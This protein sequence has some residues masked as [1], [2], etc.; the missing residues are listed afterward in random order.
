M[1]RVN[2]LFILAALSLSLYLVLRLAPGT[3]P[4]E[5]SLP[6]AGPEMPAA[7]AS[8][9]AVN[10]P[11]TMLWS[12]PGQLRDYDELILREKN[13]PAAWAGGMDPAMR[14]WLV[15]KADT[16]ALFGEAVHILERR[17]DWLRVA[18]V[19]QKT[20]LNEWGYPGW[21]PAGHIAGSEVYLQEL[22]SLP[23]VVVAKKTALLYS[24]PGLTEVQ[25]EVSYQT[26]LPLLEEAKDYV[27]VRLPEGGTGF[28]PRQDVKKEEDLAFSRSA[29]VEEAR[30]FLGVPYLWAGT[31]SY[32]FDCSGFT[33]RLYQSQGLEIPRD[34]DE[35]AR[36]GMGVARADIQPGDLLFY[37]AKGGQGQIHHVGLYAGGGLMIHAPNSHSAVRLDA[38]DSG[39]YGEEYW[40]ARRYA[41]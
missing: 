37:A 17:G 4:P 30:Q 25:V 22:G 16:M 8:R 1:K 40:G 27:K 21:V 35:Q 39:K 3:V 24:D 26:R 20:A 12:A 7:A 10:V 18:V 41:R 19:S 29:I 11:A 34:A 32:G 33:M 31:A 13:N 38:M 2:S 23:R 28:L 6:P 36:A 15:E 14:L 5:R 9:G